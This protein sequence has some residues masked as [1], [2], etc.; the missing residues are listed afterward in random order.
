[1]KDLAIISPTEF[2]R[3]YF[4]KLLKDEFC[5]S[6]EGYVK[7]FKQTNKFLEEIEPDGSIK[8]MEYKTNEYEL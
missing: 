6:S 7:I 3:I 5:R 8:I 1:M 4:L 2:L